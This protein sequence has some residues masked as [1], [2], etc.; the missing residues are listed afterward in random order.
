[1]TIKFTN[2]ATTTLAA[3]ITNV[4]TSL[5]VATGGGAKFPT[6]TG[7][8]VFYATLANSGGSV[9]IVQ[10]TARTGDAFTIV[11]AQDGTTGL[12]WTTGDK[13]ELRPV[14]AVLAAM[15]QLAAA[16]TFTGAN[17]YGTPASLVLTNA[18]GL[19][20]AG[21]GTGATTAG[22]ALTNL[23]AYAASNP[24]G[25]TSNTG[26]VTSVATGNGLSGGTITTTG[27]ISLDFYTGS[28]AGNTT[29]P[30]GS[31]VLVAP[32]GPG[33]NS[34]VQNGSLNAAVTI[35]VITTAGY[36]G[37]GYVVPGGSIGQSALAGT[38][39]NRGA[40]TVS[41]NCCGY[42]TNGPWLFQRTA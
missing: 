16:N 1:M 31:Y 24:S 15:P 2:N 9:E 41:S 6:L 35:G 4:A 33:A 20:I 17:A 5:T 7:A 34:T 42:I 3:G 14:A 18:T 39:R 21:G 8:D 37:R 29:F 12:A 28:T 25:F 26:T 23:G 10:V 40:T 22:G 30:V 32:Y 38:W 27:T 11:R 13:V 19:P 36:A